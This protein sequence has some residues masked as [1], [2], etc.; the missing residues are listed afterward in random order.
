MRLKKLFLV[1]FVLISTMLILP[2]S[3]EELPIIDIIQLED[4][5]VKV[6][7][8]SETT[9]NEFV[10]LTFT[11]ATSKVVILPKDVT[12]DS[13]SFTFLSPRLDGTFDF[14]FVY[15]E[16]ESDISISGSVIFAL[17]EKG[18]KS[19]VS[20]NVSPLLAD[21]DVP[22][23]DIRS[24]TN[25]NMI[26]ITAENQQENVKYEF[27]YSTKRSGKYKD[28][29]Q[30]RYNTD[31]YETIASAYFKNPKVGKKYYIRV[32][33][34]F[35]VGTDIQYS[36]WYMDSVKAK[37]GSIK[38]IVAK[39]TAPNKLTVTWSKAKNA[40][41]YYPFVSGYSEGAKADY[42][43]FIAN[44]GDP[45]DFEWDY[46]EMSTGGKKTKKTK[47]TYDLTGFDMDASIKVGVSLF[48]DNKQ[49]MIGILY[50]YNTIVDD[51]FCKSVTDVVVETSSSGKEV[52]LTFKSPVDLAKYEMKRDFLGKFATSSPKNINE[53][54][55]ANIAKGPSL[56]TLAYYH[57]GECLYDF[58]LFVATKYNGTYKRVK[59]V[60]DF[61]DPNNLKLSYKAKR[62]KK[63]YYKIL[64]TVESIYWETYYY[65]E[66]H[67]NKNISYYVNLVETPIIVS[68]KLPK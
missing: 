48:D 55:S 17:I 24:L 43:Y 26:I 56:K 38:N 65:P 46:Y 19:V 13:Y 4:G 3:A 51:E 18:E 32:R 7:S 37:T 47:V 59:T 20:D 54:F 34:Y 12:F 5:S 21:P 35:E 23:V 6:V 53:F 22:D 44:G 63:L 39:L 14:N 8:D 68:H 61:S 49:Q 60:A 64:P 41:N 16:D 28:L 42:D 50:Y 15:S 58:N 2:A 57:E 36:G 33:A 27:Q 67:D 29:K 10:S 9:I 40:K 31:T 52:E 62:G 30:Y 45:E 66:L 1:F 11:N 25:S